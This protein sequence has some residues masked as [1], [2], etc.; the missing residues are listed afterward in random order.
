LTVEK[1]RAVE[2]DLVIWPET[3]F[4]YGYGGVEPS[5]SDLEIARVRLARWQPGAGKDAEQPSAE[6]G[7]AVR[8]DLDASRRALA[9]M[10]DALGK[11]LLVGT[12]RQNY[13]PGRLAVYNSAVLIAPQQGEVDYYDKLHLVPF[14]EYLPLKDTLTFLRRLVPYNP[15][16]YGID[17]AVDYQSIHHDG[18]NFGVLICF[19]DTLPHITRGLL[20]SQ[21]RE[22]PIEFLVNQSNDGW[23]EG[24]IEPDYHLAASVFRCIE[25][26]LPMVRVTNLGATALIDANGAVQV[27]VAAEQRSDPGIIREVV[28]LDD[29]I[30]PYVALGDWLGWLCLAC[31]TL[32]LALSG[33]RHLRRAWE[34][35]HQ[36]R[37][38]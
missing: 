24:S 30:A 26:R 4:P 29:R 34:Q 28:P 3:M 1:A 15:E 38:S 16:T 10:T 6:L 25:S 19:E 9:R 18:L 11:P 17:A 20:R 27:A 37:E 36:P 32:G 12:I 13:Q 2:G 5:M 35:L 8:A 22:R 23:F 14:G 7:A 21:R 31:V 33:L